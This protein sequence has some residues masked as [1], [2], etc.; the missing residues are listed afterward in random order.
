MD[1]CSPLISCGRIVEDIV[2]F[3]RILQKFVELV[4]T[5]LTDEAKRS[6]RCTAPASI[7]ETALRHKTRNRQ[8]IGTQTTSESPMLSDLNDAYVLCSREQL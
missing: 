3:E 4:E 8:Q 6:G 7:N 2:D 5:I 1:R